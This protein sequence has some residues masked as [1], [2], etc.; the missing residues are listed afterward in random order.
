MHNSSPSLTPRSRAAS[1][2]G[3]TFRTTRSG[4]S[5]QGSPEWHNETGQL[6][7]AAGLQT[8]VKRV[9]GGYREVPYTAA[10]LL[11]VAASLGMQLRATAQGASAAHRIWLS[12]VP[13]GATRSAWPHGQEGLARVRV[14]VGVRARVGVG[15]GLA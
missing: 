2:G 6:L 11:E 10:E 9:G 8:R 14:R 15:L 13:T 1:S 3:Q 5:S 12:R 7:A 4:G